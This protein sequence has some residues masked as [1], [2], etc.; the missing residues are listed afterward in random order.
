MEEKPRWINE[1]FVQAEFDAIT[2]DFTRCEE[3]LVKLGNVNDMEKRKQEL[4]TQLKAG[5]T[6]LISLNV[7][8]ESTDLVASKATDSLV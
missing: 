8:R 4:G 3:Q 5:K 6:K 7:S 2:H 1:G